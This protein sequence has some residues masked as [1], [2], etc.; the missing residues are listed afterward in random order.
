MEYTHTH[1][2]THTQSTA[3]LQKC[4][5]ILVSE[6]KEKNI[7]TLVPLATWGAFPVSMVMTSKNFGAK[8]TEINRLCGEKNDMIHEKSQKHQGLLTSF[9]QNVIE[10]QQV[11]R[12]E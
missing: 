2:H 4:S 1:T 12:M 3:A 5:P 6:V 9:G 7:F 11:H 10:Y 8:E